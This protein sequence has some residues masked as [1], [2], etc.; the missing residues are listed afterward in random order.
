MTISSKKPKWFKVLQ[1]MALM[2]P[3]IGFSWFDIHIDSWVDK[4]FFRFILEKV[5]DIKN[6]RKQLTIKGTRFTA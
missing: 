5:F 1:I 3:G 4:N 2:Q 6:K